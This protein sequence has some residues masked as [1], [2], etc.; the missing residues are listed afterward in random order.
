[1]TGAEGLAAAFVAVRL[2]VVGLAVWLW[3]SPAAAGGIT[4]PAALQQRLA[5]SGL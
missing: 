4:L 2:L 5:A 3:R 1:M